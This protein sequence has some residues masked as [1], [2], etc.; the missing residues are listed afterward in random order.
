VKLSEVV[1]EAAELLAGQ[2]L[3]NHKH[4]RPE[5]PVEVALQAD[6]DGLKQVFVNLFI[7]ALEASPPGGDVRCHAEVTDQEIR[8]F[9]DDSGPG[10][11]AAPQLCLT[12]FFSTKPNGTGL[13]LTVCRNLLAAH[14]GSVA[15]ANREQGGCRAT[16]TLPRSAR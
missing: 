3:V 12:P 16:V 2:Q 7:N 4:I 11:R 10:L 5:I 8:V 1:R 13:G 14:S 9:V 15:L 6:H